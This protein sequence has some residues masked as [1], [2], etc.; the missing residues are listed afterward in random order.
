MKLIHRFSTAP[1]A[2]LREN[3]F[4]GN[5]EEEV[6]MSMHSVFR[7]DDLEQIEDRLWQIKLSLTSDNDPLLTQ[8]TE[9][10]R[11]EIGGEMPLYRM[12]CLMMKMG[13]YD[14]AQEILESLLNT[15]SANDEH[16]TAVLNYQLG[17]VLLKK[18]E[19]KNSLSCLEKTLEFEQKIFAWDDPALMYTYRSLGGCLSF[20]GRLSTSPWH[21]IKRRLKFNKI[22]LRAIL[23]I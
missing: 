3:S 21:T 18:G 4:Y 5:E 12:S 8:L 10:L 6:L 23:S 20:N 22:R 11:E 19:L 2:F 16:L 17:I 15:V 1:F 14:K 7:I 13:H 9:Y